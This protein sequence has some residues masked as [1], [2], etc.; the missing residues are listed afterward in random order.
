MEGYDFSR[1]SPT[2][3]LLVAVRG[4]RTDIPFAKE[5][6]AH[7]RATGASSL[8]DYPKDVAR[9][10][11]AFFEARFKSVSRILSEHGFSQVLELAAKSFLSDK[12]A[13]VLL[14]D[15]KGHK[16]GPDVFS[17]LK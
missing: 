4:E 11:A 14:G 1:V 3:L 8:D 17:E 13:L 6:L 7:L 15:L 2:A 16:F 10:Y 9:S 5:M 12:M